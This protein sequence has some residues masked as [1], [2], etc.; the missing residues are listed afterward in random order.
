MQNSYQPPFKQYLNHPVNYN[1]HVL[2]HVALYMA[3]IDESSNKKDKATTDSLVNAC[4][5]PF[6]GETPYVRF[7]NGLA[8]WFYQEKYDSLADRLANTYIQST[9]RFSLDP[10]NFLYFN[11]SETISNLEQL[12]TI[13]QTFGRDLKQVDEA[14]LL[15]SRE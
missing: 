1:N 7:F 8:G 13:L 9:L 4:F 14:I 12:K 15:L 3:L 5:A 2:Y 6:T 10:N 11:K